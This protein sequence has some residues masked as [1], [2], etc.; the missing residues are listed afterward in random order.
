MNINFNDVEPDMYDMPEF[1]YD[2]FIKQDINAIRESDYH[3]I[4]KSTDNRIIYLLRQHPHFIHLYILLD[5]PLCM[6]IIEDMLNDGTIFD[7]KFNM[8]KLM[9]FKTLNKNGSLNV[10]EILRKKN[11]LDFKYLSK[12]PNA[13]DTLKNNKD[14][15][16]WDAFSK[17][18]AIFTY[19]YNEIKRLKHDINKE[20]IEC[21]FS[22]ERIE[23][24][25]LDNI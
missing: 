23:N 4:C 15:I 21:A 13:I 25:L 12:N 9:V 20:V 18:P 19:D 5:N 1:S 16:C 7:N 2:W 6:S 14:K 8:D 22:P 10:L 17:N 3:R 24:K 11:E